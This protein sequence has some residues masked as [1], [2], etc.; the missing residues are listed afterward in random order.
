MSFVIEIRFKDN[1]GH[2]L[3]VRNHQTRLE[4]Q[5][6]PK[7]R[8]LLIC[9]IPPWCPNKAIS[10]LFGRFGKLENVEIQLRPGKYE[11]NK[12]S[13]EELV[14]RFRVAYIVF[15]S[16]DA[17]AK[18]KAFS[19]KGDHLVISTGQ[20]PIVTGLALFC[21]EYNKSFPDIKKLQNEINT[22]MSEFESKD[23]SKEDGVEDGWS[24]VGKKK[25]QRLTEAEQEDSRLKAAKKRK[26]G[27]LIDFY[28][29]Q[30]RESKK[31]KIIELREKF[32]EDKKRIERMKQERRFRPQT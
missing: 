25:T 30:I 18:V 32:E 27:Q 24:K 10:R 19:D 21:A 2:H 22:F 4:Q 5:T 23:D 12:C 1:V 7:G 14:D 28:Q 16:E 6:R 17:L 31:Q 11:E 3:F 26:K 20:D 15:S 9:N 8:T 13:E 29:F